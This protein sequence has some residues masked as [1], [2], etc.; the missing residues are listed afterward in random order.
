MRSAASAWSI[1]VKSG[2]TPT[3]RPKPRSSRFA[4][5]WNVPPQTRPRAWRPGRP[6]PSASAVIRA[7]RASISRAARR[8]NVSSRIRSGGVPFAISQATRH[9]SV[10]VLPVPAPA[11]TSTVPSPQVAASRWA[12]FSPSSHWDS[13]AGDDPEGGASASRTNTCS[14]TLPHATDG[15]GRASCTT[16]TPSRSGPRAIRSTRSRTKRPDPSRAGW[17]GRTGLSDPGRR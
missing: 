14:T 16:T 3:L 4:V 12:S 2:R 13:I 8:V 15:P 17:L 5:A 6:P 7:A 1:T 11:T 9:A 10:I